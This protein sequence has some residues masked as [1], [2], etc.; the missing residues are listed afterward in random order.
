MKTQTPTIA[1]LVVCALTTGADETINHAKLAQKLARKRAHPLRF[2]KPGEAELFHA[3]KRAPLGR[4]AVPTARYLPALR[5]ADDMPR[6]STRRS[7]ALPS[8][9]VMRARGEQ[10]PQTDGWTWLGPGNIGGRTRALLVHPTKPK[11]MYAAGVAGGVWQSTDA[12]ESWRPLTDTLANLAVCCL[13]MDRKN[14]HLIYAG[15]GEG[16]G[17]VDLVRGAGIFKTTD[18]GKTWTHLPGTKRPDFYYVNDMAVSPND[19]AVAYAATRTGV[20]RTED[21]GVQWTRVLEPDATGGFVALEIRTDRNPTHILA[22]CGIGKG[23]VY[24][25][26]N[27]G[28]KGSWKL[29]L[30]GPALGR[31]SLAFAASNQQIAYALCASAAK[32]PYKNGLHAVYRSDDGGA[33]WQERVSNSDRKLLNTLLLSNPYFGYCG[34]NRSLLNQGWYDNVIAVDPTDPDTVWTGGISLFRSKDGGRNWELANCWWAKPPYV[35][36][37]TPVYC[38]A[39]QHAIV[40]HPDYDG[41]E[42]QILYV[43]NDGGVFETRNA[44]TGACTTN[45]CQPNKDRN[46]VA[47]RSLSHGYGVTQ[48]YHGL[49]FPGGADYVGGAQDNGTLRG[50]DSLGP[51]GWDM[52]IGGDG[53][54]VAIDHGNPS[55]VYAENYGVSIKKSTDGGKTF[56][57]VVNGITENAGNFLFIVPFTMDPS[58][59]RVLWTGGSVPWRTTDAAASWRQ[60]GARSV[61]QYSFSAF[62]VSPTDSNRVLAGSGDGYVLR[63]D[64]GLR[65]DADTAWSYARPV[66]GYISSLAFDPFEPQTVYATCSTFG[67]KHVLRSLNGGADWQR[68]EGAGLDA[69]PDVPAHTIVADPFNKGRLYVGTDIGVFVSTN[70][71]QSWAVEN[72]NFANTVTEHLAIE[73]RSRRLFAFT[74]GRG[75]YRIPLDRS[76]RAVLAKSSYRSDFSQRAGRPPQV[77]QQDEDLDVFVREQGLTD[78]SVPNTSRER[79]DAIRVTRNA[80][81]EL[82]TAAQEPVQLMIGTEPD[83]ATARIRLRYTGNRRP[84]RSFAVWFDR[85]WIGIGTGMAL[86]THGTGVTLEKT[87]IAENQLHWIFSHSLDPG[88]T[89]NVYREDRGQWLK[90]RTVSCVTD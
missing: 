50:A 69:L 53:G 71:G 4:R 70:A 22:S 58:N 49:P 8:R 81:F 63:T 77:E 41:R 19:S 67:Q 64:R 25:S 1:V 54:Y 39:D 16:F 52:I 89:V 33:S 55:I 34:N 88:Q 6:W 12:G 20:W 44:R 24:R 66:Q 87:A 17:N 60:A 43:G 29:V 65:A 68:I 76:A 59:A 73:K 42:N 80:T 57:R 38:H 13:A 27:D 61:N 7:V 31:I 84:A 36:S 83:P 3:A 15:T 21:A 72:N 11:I 62:A 35:A 85:G 23:R 2:D 75:V 30:S 45:P 79:H 40:F 48:F 47:W 10:P 74:H 90:I 86:E 26:T 9:N 46:A 18:G 28:R 56:N 5:A 32:G 37:E 14:P 82:I 78:R 51:D